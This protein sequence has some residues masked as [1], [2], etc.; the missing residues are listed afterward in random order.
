MPRRFAGWDESAFDVLLRL[1]GEPSQEVMRETRKDRERLVRQPMVSL[2]HDL[3]RTDPVFEDHSVWRYGK[4]P[5]WWQNQSAVVRIAPNV[6]IGFRFN[7]EGLHMQGAWWYA[8]SDQISRFRAAVA[9]EASGSVLGDVVAEL[10]GKGFEINGDVLKRAPRG[11]P[12]E[13]PRTT[14]LRHRSLL[15][16]RHLGCDEQLRTPEVVD[17]VL[18]TREELGPLLTWLTDH[19]AP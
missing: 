12:A 3:A 18:A 1:E 14:L 17:R 13:H 2:L 7:L 15:A 10:R 11:Y 4:T 9:A 5:W 16:V 6:E 8:G 19:V